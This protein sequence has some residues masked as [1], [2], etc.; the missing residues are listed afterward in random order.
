MI[1]TYGKCSKKDMKLSDMAST[2]VNLTVTTTGRFLHTWN[3]ILWS[4]KN[5]WWIMGRQE[6][7]LK[8]PKCVP[9]SHMEAAAAWRTLWSQIREDDVCQVRLSRPDL[10]A[11]SFSSRLWPRADSVKLHITG[12]GAGVGPEQLM[13]PTC[14]HCE[15]ACHIDNG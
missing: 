8:K 7:R 3:F 9:A 4:K 2:A 15:V 6:N 5:R 11:S 10:S 12:C 14:I 1:W 13:L